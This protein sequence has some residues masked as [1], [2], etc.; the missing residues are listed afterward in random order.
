[1]LAYMNGRAARLISATLPHTRVTAQAEL[2]FRKA[3]AHAEMR[4]EIA[5]EADG[6][7]TA[8]AHDMFG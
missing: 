2:A 4:P 6:W 7:Y 3:E 1:M 8:F 5:R